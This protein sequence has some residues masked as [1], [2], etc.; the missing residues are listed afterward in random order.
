VNFVTSWFRPKLFFLDSLVLYYAISLL[1]NTPATALS[2]FK[3]GSVH[4]NA[5]VNFA[6][7]CLKAAM[8]TRRVCT[9]RRATS[10][11]QL[12]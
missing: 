10:A 1:M 7:C 8:F 3:I 11:G 6:S 2:R 4:R 12:V 5:G 9:P